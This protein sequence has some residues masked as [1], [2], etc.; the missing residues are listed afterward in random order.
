[1]NQFTGETIA[2]E[3]TS[4]DDKS[5]DTTLSQKP[6]E[7]IKAV[8]GEVVIDK[9]E[10]AGFSEEDKAAP[11]TILSSTSSETGV[12]S[13]SPKKLAANRRNAQRSTGPKSA[14]G[15]ATSRQNALKHGILASS[16]LIVAAL[17]DADEF[18]QLVNALIRDL[19]P[20]GAL[21]E[22]LVEKIAV[23]CWREARALRCERGSV[24]QMI[25]TVGLKDN[26]VLP[27][28][29]L[30]RILR[31]ETSIHRQLAYSTSQL[32]R[33]QRTRKGEH[34]PAPVTVQLSSDE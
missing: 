19:A 1:M 3:N 2:R 11:E 12:K 10:S 14:K 33:L 7:I 4:L 15:K 5:S 13:V 30:D 8:R 16:L 26:L 34:V 25:K 17:E 20:V 28:N 22:M 32:E 6:L 24:Q 18:Q 31:Y 27:I 29:D 23:C 9:A 21:E